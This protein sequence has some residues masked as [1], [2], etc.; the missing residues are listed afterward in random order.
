MRRLQTN[1]A[2]P[3]SWTAAGQ[4]GQVFFVAAGLFKMVFQLLLGVPPALTDSAPLLRRRTGMALLMSAV[5]PRTSAFF[6]LILKSSGMSHTALLDHFGKD[7]T[8]T[9][10]KTLAEGTIGQIL[11]NRTGARPTL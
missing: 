9:G 11:A 7:L 4:G 6:T 3:P 10:E 8:E 2:P 5:L 1:A